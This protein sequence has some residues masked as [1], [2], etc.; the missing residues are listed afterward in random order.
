M[1]VP[2]AAGG[3]LRHG[4][5]FAALIAAGVAPVPP[6][7]AQDATAASAGGENAGA[8]VAAAVTDSLDAATAAGWAIRPRVEARMTF[9]DNVGLT[10]DKR[11]DLV[12]QII[13]GVSVSRSGRRI[14]LLA[15]YD[16]QN[17][18]YLRDGGRNSTYHQLALDGNAEV[19]RDLLFV[20]ARADVRQSAGNLLQPFSADNVN[21]TGNIENVRSYSVSPYLTQRLGTFAFAEARYT[22]SQVSTEFA[23]AADGTTD[24][25][26]ARLSSGTRFS[27]LSWGLTA[28]QSK[29]DYAERT[30]IESREVAAD[31]GTVL[32][33]QFR[34]FG[35]VGYEENK[36]LLTTRD[37]SDRFWRA[38]LGWAPSSRTKIEGSVGERFFGRTYALDAS[39]RARRTSWQ[40][41][42]SENLSTTQDEFIIPARINTAAFLDTLYQTSIPD[43]LERRQRI[44]DQILNFGLAGF[45]NNPYNL[46]T[47]QVF[48]DKRLN[49]SVNL[50]AR[51]SSLFLSLFRSER[52][53]LEEQLLTNQIFGTQTFGS[54]NSV[55]QMGGNAS[56]R[57]RVTPTLS[58][59]ADVGY[60]RLDFP[61]VPREDD[62]YTMR[63]GVSRSFSRR[64]S[65]AV[66][67]RFTERASTQSLGDYQENA[68]TVSVLLRF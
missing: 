41:N 24:S 9:T 8:Q 36:F 54:E 62:L 50:N 12:T 40:L 6:S 60:T 61:L 39:Y 53:S 59:N 31:L 42:Y 28:S 23:N 17:L 56:L 65:G 68:V 20:D 35:T 52:E 2:E 27:D 55:T 48:L 3:R 14:R 43:P 11:A 16:L 25:V 10:R 21:A 19:L 26:F 18:F 13:P 29:S 37:P 64:L 38:G 34:V 45:Y 33:R 49:G 57:V 15:D 66:D 63:A 30:D 58:A 46:F 32:G 67:Y 51:K 22:R 44:A 4:A 7:I 5:L 1:A 47:E